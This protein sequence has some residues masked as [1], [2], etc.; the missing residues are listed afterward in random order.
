MAEG[1]L[2]N[3]DATLEVFSAGTKAEQQVNPY[4]VKVMA[5]IGIDISKQVPKS[6]DIFLEKAFD[7]VITVCDSAK[8]ACPY[9]SGVVQKRR[10]MG[11]EDPA[12][13]KGTEAEIM[14]VYRKI[15]DEIKTEFYKFYLENIK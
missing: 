4:A 14:M 15:R 1:I 8:E 2:K 11:F 3:L 12:S 7:F 10:H 9:F 13:A 5:E 6:V